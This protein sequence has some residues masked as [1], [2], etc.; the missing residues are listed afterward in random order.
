MKSEQGKEK[1]GSGGVS[2]GGSARYPFGSEGTHSLGSDDGRAAD[3]A[4]APDFFRT[5]VEAA[6]RKERE[7]RNRAPGLWMPGPDELDRDPEP[8]DDTDFGTDG[9]EREYT[10]R[11]LG[12]RLRPKHF[13]RLLEAAR[14]YGV[15]P[16]T[17]ARMMI[18]RGIN[19]I[20]EG[21]LRARAR[22]LRDLG[23]E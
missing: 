23:S 7:E 22:E 4:T 10:S 13:E 14:L 17:M 15:R 18:I 11:Q 12:V 1:P 19:A 6:A 20:H 21:E 3:E 5:M 16:T 8:G 9:P 2:S